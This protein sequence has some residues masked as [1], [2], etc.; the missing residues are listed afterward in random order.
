M[1]ITLSSKTSEPSQWLKDL[2]RR[3]LSKLEKFG[4]GQIE[5]LVVVVDRVK[6]GHSRNTDAQLEIQMFASGKRYA[7]KE[8]GPNIPLVL[9]CVSE[10]IEKVLRR[11]HRARTSKKSRTSV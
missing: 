2:V 10:Q 1:Q 8:V 11:T 5:E 9:A 7:F 6:R 3:K 4:S